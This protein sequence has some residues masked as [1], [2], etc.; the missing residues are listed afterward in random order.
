LRKLA[1]KQDRKAPREQPELAKTTGAVPPIPAA[2]ALSFLRETRGVSTWCG[3]DLARALKISEGAAKQVAAVLELQG[4]VKRIKGDEWMTT[5]PGE[6]VSGSKMPRYTRERV[7][8]ALSA[9][10]TRIAEIN[11]ES[12]A[13][14]KITEAVAYGDFLSDRPRIQS[15]E[16]GIQLLRR[17]PGGLVADSAV[18]QSAQQEF[19]KQLKTK[20]GVVH[21]RPFEKWMADRAHRNLL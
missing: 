2:E 3:S 8:E 20:G 11:R 17:K 5:L 14:F 18:E 16:V 6:D 15:A 10:R 13:P 19:L 7:E 4:Y 21:I 1:R 12:S 9:L